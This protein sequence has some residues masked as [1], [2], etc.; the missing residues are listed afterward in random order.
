MKNKNEVHMNSSNEEKGNHAGKERK[1]LTDFLAMDRGNTNF[2]KIF[3]KIPSKFYEYTGFTIVL[4]MMGLLLIEEVYRIFFGNP[5]VELYINFYYL[6]GAFGEIFAVVYICSSFYGKKKTTLKEFFAA[7]IWDIAL[8]IMLFLSILSALNATDNS[9][10]IK[11]TSYRHD[12]LYTYFVYA[13]MYVCAKAV[14][15]N[16]LRVWLLRGIGIT[17]TCLSLMS[18]PQ[19]S[20]ELMRKWGKIGQN[21]YQYGTYSSIFYNPNHFGYIL[22]IGLMALAGLVIIDKSLYQK[23]LWLC[24][25]ALDVWALIVNDTFGSYVAVM[26]GVLF[27]AVI[28]LINDRERYKSV[29]AVLTVF[30]AMSVGM[31]AYNHTLSA[32]FGLTYKESAEI[33]TNDGAGSG[34]I[35]LWKQAVQYIKEKPILGFGP[36]GLA[37]R[38]FEDGFKNDRPHNE[39]LQHGVFL[40]I[41]ALVCYLTALFSVFVYCIK[42]VR[43]L[44]PCMLAVGG[45]V[46]GYCISAFFGNTMYYTTPYYFVFLGMLSACSREQ[47]RI[48]EGDI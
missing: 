39:Y 25:F 36:E 26:L 43:A 4:M 41:P 13:G 9:F 28:M 19:T 37:D 34:R 15:N 32:N 3:Q 33:S 18:I 24:M 38:Y 2:E 20:Y 5:R 48:V 10:A 16:K 22:V 27:L 35:G 44:S 23:L 47:N 31:D 45:I 40:G 11:G 1:G 7:H 30:I 29:I 42:R 14:R 21:L 6:V 8:A 46:F 12:G 17:V